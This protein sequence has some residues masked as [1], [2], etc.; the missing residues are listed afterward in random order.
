MLVGCN[1]DGSPEFADADCGGCVHWTAW[2][3][4]YGLGGSAKS[5]GN[6][7]GVAYDM[8]GTVAGLERWIDDCHLVGFYGGYNATNVETD[9]SHV[10]SI[11]GGQFGG[12]FMLNDG[13]SYYTLLGGFAFDGFDTHRLMQFDDINRTADS[14]YTGWQSFW[15]IERGF[16]F[17]NCNRIL[18]PF[19]A[20]QYDYLRQNA[21][22]ET[23]A[24]SIDLAGGGV[25][26]N[27]LRSILAHDCN[28]PCTPARE[29]DSCPKCMLSGCTSI[30]IPTRS[31]MRISLLCR[32]AAPDSQY[33]AWTLAAIGLCSAQLHLGNGRWV[34]PVRE[35][36]LPD[37]FATDGSYWLR[38]P[39]VQLV[40]PQSSTVR[41]A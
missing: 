31:L 11:N 16:T 27:S 12:Y 33:R 22:N 29:G 24:D 23:G 21:F 19:V 2:T 20:L 32:S 25:T 13:F 8:G 26:T 38:R 18:Q 35:L 36:R 41:F 30:W 15:Y 5:D 10:S 4:G 3:Q 40:V 6:A 14:D 7:P 9:I 1:E 17:Q 37:E 28:T 39:R 34:E